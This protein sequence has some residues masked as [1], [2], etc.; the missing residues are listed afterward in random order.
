[1]SVVNY[2]HLLFYVV[3]NKRTD[4]DTMMKVD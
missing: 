4:S 1:V 2:L 3:T